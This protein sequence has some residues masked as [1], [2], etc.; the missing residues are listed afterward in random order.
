MQSLRRIWSGPFETEDG[1]SLELVD[2]L[3]KTPEL[4]SYLLPIETGLAELPELTCRPEASAR[5]RN[6]NPGMVLASD[7]EYGE[8]AWV[9]C[10]GEPIAI[11]IYRAGE[12]HPSRVFVAPDP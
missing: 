4:D 5:L 3:A 11:G 1:I 10:D 6:G 8:E 12:L 9:S 7:V 2:E